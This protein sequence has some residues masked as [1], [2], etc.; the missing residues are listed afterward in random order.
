MQLDPHA[1]LTGNANATISDMD[2][3]NTGQEE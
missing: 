2:L 1:D 3:V